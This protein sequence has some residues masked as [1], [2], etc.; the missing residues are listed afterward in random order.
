[1]TSEEQ[2]EEWFD[3]MQD[4]GERCGHSLNQQHKELLKSAWDESRCSIVIELP[5]PHQGNFGWMH[6]DFACQRAIEKAG[7]KW[8]QGPR[9]TLSD[10]LKEYRK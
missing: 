7:V 6:Q 8:T 9:Q 2:F 3:M 1:M 10:I 4:I 5:S